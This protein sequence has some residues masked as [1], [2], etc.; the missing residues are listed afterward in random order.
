F[1]HDLSY[2]GAFELPDRWQRQLAVIAAQLETVDQAFSRFE[3]AIRVY[4]SRYGSYLSAEE[5]PGEIEALEMVLAADP[6]NPEL[7]WRIA[8]LAILLE[9]WER[10][11]RVLSEQVRRRGLDSVPEPV[12]RDLGVVRCKLNRSNRR[13]RG[14]REGQGYLRAAIDAAPRDT[15]ALTSYAGTWRGVD[16]ARAREFYRRAF[17]TDPTDY[18]PLG[19]FLEYEILRSGGTS[20]VA[21]VRP[22]LEAAIER[23]EA[24]AEVKINLPWAHFGIGKL[25]LLL[26][27]PERSL[28][29][30]A[31]GV[32]SST[33]AFMI[34]GAL[35]SLES[36]SS[37]RHELRGHDW[38]LRMLVLGAVAKFPSARARARVREL[39]SPHPKVEGPVVIVVGGTHPV[40]EER[41][42]GYR[43][44]VLE[45]FRG[46]RGTIVCGGTEQGVSG[47]IGEVAERYGDVV[48]AIAYHPT[49]PAADAT[50]DPRYSEIRKT[51]GDAFS[52]L[53]P[54]QGWIDLV[55]SGVD[56][57]DVKVL[58][59]DGG[60]IAGIEY[61]I[62]LAL[63]ASVGV[64]EESGRAAS[65]LLADEAWLGSRNLVPLPE[66]PQTVRLFI[67]PRAP[68]LPADVRD[69]LAREIH[70]RHRTA[71][72]AAPLRPWPDLQ[73]VFKES[74]RLQADHIYEKLREAGYTVTDSTDRPVE[75]FDFD[76][77]EV[78]RLA[79]MEHGR[80][81]VERLMDGWR[82]GEKRDEARRTHPDLVP[83]AELPEK[84]KEYDRKAVRG[85]PELLRLVGLKIRRERGDPGGG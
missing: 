18:Y 4:G 47:L 63:G 40:V 11:D 54:L 24:Q 52:P 45:A 84:V 56:P 7:A 61:R 19:H 32:Q 59:I 10:A 74:S 72:S 57:R 53:E 35:T 71:T 51:D 12:L 43:D 62:A 65:G 23:C 73:D 38:A 33:A 39:A 79:E 6:D 8:K 78:E 60:D 50:V 83:W 28:R 29:A 36:L 9:D 42:A 77:R 44:I 49:P 67:G 37:L 26:G 3:E 20:I 15:D 2:K 80:W 55:A 64:I 70:E 66:D 25:S 41:M 31:K 75:L 30:L 85:I 69:T 22:V 34:E 76:F 68:E 58:G 82:W 48:R 14:Y 21:S 46:F 27:E 1:G 5:I 16:E 13:G 17:D 81:N